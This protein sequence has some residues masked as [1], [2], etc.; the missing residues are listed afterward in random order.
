VARAEDIALNRLASDGSQLFHDEGWANRLH[1]PIRHFGFEMTKAEVSALS[2]Q[3]DM[4][5]L[6]AYWDAVRQR[7]IQVVDALDLT[8]LTYVVSPQYIH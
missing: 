2:E 3:V 5:A 7:T 4:E 6:R 1:M 8:T